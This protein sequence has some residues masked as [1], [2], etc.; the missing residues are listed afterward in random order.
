MPP[1]GEDTGDGPTGGMVA[2]ANESRSRSGNSVIYGSRVTFSTWQQRYLRRSSNFCNVVTASETRLDRGGPYRGA[3]DFAT[4]P[5]CPAYRGAGILQLDR[6]GGYTGGAPPPV[7]HSVSRRAIDVDSATRPASR[8]HGGYGGDRTGSA[9]R[10]WSLRWVR[11]T[12]RCA[13]PP[14]LASRGSDW[15]KKRTRSAG[16]LWRLRIQFGE[17]RVTTLF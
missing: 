2:P 14:R 15:I 12:C 6:A 17:L 5:A 11:T 7:V 10:A 1:P 4:R 3:E 13:T 9:S 8:P 16:P